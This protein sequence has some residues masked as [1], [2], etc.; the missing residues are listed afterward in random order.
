MGADTVL[1]GQG[2]DS[3]QGGQGG[4]YLSGDLGDDVLRGGQGDDQLLGGAGDDFLS[5]DVGADTL[6]GGAGAD[7][8]HISVGS[9]VDLVTDFNPAEGDRV[10]LEPGTS[11]TVSQV[12]ADV[13]VDLAGGGELV[14]AHVQLSSLA[15][16]WIVA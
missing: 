4:D 12:G 14:L 16:G 1:G 5:G 15:G 9:G 2:A 6:T 11:Y 8:F 13:H 7:T 3:L 10:L